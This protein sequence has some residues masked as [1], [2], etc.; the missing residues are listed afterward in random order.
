M[1]IISSI[2]NKI[3]DYQYSTLDLM[4]IC[5]LLVFSYTPLSSVLRIKKGIKGNTRSPMQRNK[6]YT[7]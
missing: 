2:N 5:R 4:K 3:K 6:G 7:V 1:I